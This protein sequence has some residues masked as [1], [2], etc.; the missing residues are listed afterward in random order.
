[1]EL[2]VKENE[3]DAIGEESPRDSSVFSMNWTL[4]TGEAAAFH[5]TSAMEEVFSRLSMVP[6]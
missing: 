3:R 1:M 6:N 5:R 4:L 2:K